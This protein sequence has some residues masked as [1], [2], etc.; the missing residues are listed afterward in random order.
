MISLCYNILVFL[1]SIYMTI[2]FLQ[3]SVA[4]T[5]D[6]QY[7][8]LKGISGSILGFPMIVRKGEGEGAC[9]AFVRIRASSTG[10]TR[11]EDFVV[12]HDSPIM[13]ADGETGA[14]PV[15]IL[16]ALPDNV[17]EGAEKLFFYID[18][19]TGG[20]I[21]NGSRN[22]MEVYIVDSP[23]REVNFTVDTVT[24]PDT[25]SMAQ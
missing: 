16:L 20:E 19:V 22:T 8:G 12:R 25:I 18:S 13:W 7:I 6:N 3:Q 17:K 14:K 1:W 10:A 2:E 21:V 4:V 24:V 5:E 11:N 15:D 23:A 9:S